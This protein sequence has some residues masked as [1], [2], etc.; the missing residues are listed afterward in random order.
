MTYSPTKTCKLNKSTFF[1][2]WGAGEVEEWSDLSI[3]M[4][5]IVALCVALAVI[6]KVIG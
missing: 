2:R 3:I 1:T 6:L 5:Y 4:A